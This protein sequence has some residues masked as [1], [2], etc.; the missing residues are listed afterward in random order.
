MIEKDTWEAKSRKQPEWEDYKSTLKLVLPAWKQQIIIVTY[1]NVF[2][3]LFL[4][5]F[6]VHVANK[7]GTMM[8]MTTMMPVVVAVLM[9]MMM[10][11]HRSR[12]YHS[13][14]LTK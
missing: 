13:I 10:M 7:Y 11:T 12:S 14:L 2:W 6:K 4:V 9:M 3:K 8:M 1:I 5:Y